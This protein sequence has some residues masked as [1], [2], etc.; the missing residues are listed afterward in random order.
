[1][2]TGGHISMLKRQVSK[3]RAAN[4]NCRENII[5]EAA[6]NIESIWTEDVEFNRDTMIMYANSLL[7]WAILKYF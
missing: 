7:N 4:P 3:F 6:D 5:E 2:L 1:M